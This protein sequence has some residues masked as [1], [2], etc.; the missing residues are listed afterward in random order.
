MK[1]VTV[2]ASKKYDVLIGEDLLDK[3][4]ALIKEK[5]GTCRICIVS[6]D[7]VASLYK[8]RTQKSLKKEGFDTISF[9]F[10]HGEESKNTANLIELTE[11]LAQNHFSRTDAIVALGGGVVGDLA[12]FVAAVYLRGIRFVQIPTTLLAAVDS[13]V[14]GKTAVDLAAGKN[15]MGAFHQPSLVICDIKTLDTLPAS[16]FSDGCAEV[17]KYGVINNREFFDELKSG[18]KNNIIDV[19]AK[20]VSQKADIVMQ[21]E[22]DKGCRQL[23][24][25][26]HTVGH[27]IE[28]RSDFAISHGSAVA[29]GM[30]IATKI[31]V[32]LNLCK[33]EELDELID[34]LQANGLPTACS[35]S[36][37]ELAEIASVDEKRVGD[38]VSFVIPYSIGRCELM[39]VRVEDLVSFISKGL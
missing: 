9:V 30:V 39:K 3:A 37:S 19:I 18:I 24:N 22:F 38:S 36:A 20:C 2:N 8:E 1:S 11:F 14:G 5:L 31:S 6:D 16:T 27:A 32:A 35:Y 15:L 13:S 12:G 25:L 33:Q 21:D 28:A 4:G 34:I 17:I 29:I 10:A 23:L 7:T 26:G